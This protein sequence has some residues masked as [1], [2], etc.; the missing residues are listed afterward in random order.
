[1]PNGTS[2][3][4]DFLVVSAPLLSPLCLAEV[5][6]MPSGFRFHLPFPVG[7]LLYH[8]SPSNSPSSAS[9]G[10]TTSPAGKE[11]SFPNACMA[12][13]LDDVWTDSEY[14]DLLGFGW[15]LKCLQ[16][17]RFVPTAGLI[18]IKHSQLKLMPCYFLSWSL[19][20]ARWVRAQKCSLAD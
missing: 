7:C 3:E 4:S 5:L 20:S 19:M 8:R 11:F 14:S 9:F 1:M 18:G 10:Y 16:A 15:W 12:S 6:T 17:A 13:C 2:I